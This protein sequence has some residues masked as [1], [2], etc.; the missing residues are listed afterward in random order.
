MAPQWK[1]VLKLSVLVCLIVLFFLRM[2][3][4]S[5]QSESESAGH[6]AIA[7]SN[8]L[9]SQPGYVLELN[10]SDESKTES[11]RDA[12]ESGHDTIATSDPLFRQHGYV[13][14]LN[15]SDQ[16]TGGGMNVMSLQCLVSNF[17][18]TVLVEPFVI[19]AT[20]GAFLWGDLA[21]FEYDNNIRLSDIYRLEQWN[22][23]TD[24]MHYHRLSSW[25]EF[26]QNAPRDLI[27]VVNQWW[28]DCNLD[29]REKRFEPFFQLHGFKVVRSVCSNF[30]HSGKLT[31]GQYKKMI[32]GS[33]SV[34]SV[35]VIIDRFPGIC[36]LGI[37]NC[38]PDS[39]STSIIGTPCSKWKYWSL[40]RS[41]APSSRVI[42]AA[43]KYIQRYLDE[44]EGYISMMVRL[45]FAVVYFTDTGR[46]NNL[47]KVSA[48]LDRLA[49]KL[50]E[51]QS[52]QELNSTFLALDVGRYGS[53]V[54]KRREN[55]GD[56]LVKVKK[57]FHGIHHGSNFELWEQCYAK[58]SGLQA[59]A[60]GTGGFVA[61]LQKEIAHRGHC[62]II[63]GGGT[64][65]ESTLN[66]YKSSHTKHCFTIFD[67]SC[68]L[69]HEEV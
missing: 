14:E 6:D 27:L 48:C 54:M 25:E 67:T 59:S 47:S 40:F 19:N 33:Y 49:R 17:G 42:Q 9:L 32:Y 4:W 18:D 34:S 13:L 1:T 5:T 2:V 23:Y 53:T 69:T 29:L 38:E 39:F 45:E 62:L 46:A 28:F 56:T 21:A 43:D 41:I 55:Y 11:G 50:T 66:L 10:F 64:F 37:G 35:T 15:A 30:K 52:R 51:V 7:R 20:F 63:G 3:T 16:L 58:V 24:Q 26:L 60:L 61:M 36:A 65:Q 22:N 12:T 57:F 68:T 44:R 31:M 8:P